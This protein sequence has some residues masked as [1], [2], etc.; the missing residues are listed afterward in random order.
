MNDK[1]KEQSEKTK[2]NQEKTDKP[3]EKPVFVNTL[4]DS[5]E[6]AEGE[7]TPEDGYTFVFS[8]EE[9]DGKP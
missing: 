3:E 6:F 4:K 8:V 9:L 5:H 7:D 2:P 1:E